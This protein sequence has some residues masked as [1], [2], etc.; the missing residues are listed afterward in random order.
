MSTLLGLPLLQRMLL[1]TQPPNEPFV[2][3]LLPSA[4]SK[5]RSRTSS[6]VPLHQAKTSNG[7]QCLLPCSCQLVS[8]WLMGRLA[9][10]SDIRQSSVATCPSHL[11]Y[12]ACLSESGCTTLDTR[13]MALTAVM[14]SGYI[15][16]VTAASMAQPNAGASDTLHMTQKVRFS[17]WISVNCSAA[18]QQLW[19]Q[20]N[21]NRKA[22]NLHH[23]NY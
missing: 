10:K 20:I 19:V 11:A 18:L 9:Y 7:T 15:P 21:N 4:P 1:E 14:M 8:N 6:F 5:K 13:T 2:S 3:I 17:V 12:S 23:A 22:I 16:A